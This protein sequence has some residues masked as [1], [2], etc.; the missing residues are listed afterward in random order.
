MRILERGPGFS[1]L[2][3][4]DSHTPQHNDI[5]AQLVEVL[6]T[7]DVTDH[8][9]ILGIVIIIAFINQELRLDLFLLLRFFLTIFAL[10]FQ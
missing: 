10:T 4:T 1:V 8:P 6:W 3:F 7:L 5:P 9:I 2:F